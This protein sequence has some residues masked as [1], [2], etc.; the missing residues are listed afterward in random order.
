M[1]GTKGKAV[2]SFVLSNLKRGSGAGFEDTI[3]EGVDHAGVARVLIIKEDTEV[4][5][6]GSALSVPELLNILDGG[7]AKV[8]AVGNFAKSLAL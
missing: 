8:C 1:S 6:N 4:S 7:S 3:I 5:Q 2:E